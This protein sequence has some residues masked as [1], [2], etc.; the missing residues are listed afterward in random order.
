MRLGA[1]RRD[2]L[3]LRLGCSIMLMRLQELCKTSANL[4]GFLLSYFILAQSGKI[5]AQL[6]CK[7]FILFCFVLLQMSKPL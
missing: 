5:F 4:V 6:L 3:Q 2:W 7:N 1:A